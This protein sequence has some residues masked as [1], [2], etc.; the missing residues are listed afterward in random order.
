M[1]IYRGILWCLLIVFVSAT[2]IYIG[3]Y[4][5]EQRSNQEGTLIWREMNV[6]GNGIC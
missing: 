3:Y 6:A 2:I 4:I 5:N 1:K